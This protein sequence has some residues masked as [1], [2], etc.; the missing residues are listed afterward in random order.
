[1]ADYIPPPR[2]PVGIPNL[3]AARPKTPVSKGGG[4]RKRWKDHRGNI[5]EWDYQH[6]TIEKY[7][8]RGIHLGEF[9]PDTGQMLKSANRSRSVVP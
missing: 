4:L 6:G 3:H 1:M 7:N 5:Y 2:L 8:R 9:N